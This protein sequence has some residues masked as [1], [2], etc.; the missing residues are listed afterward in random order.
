VVYA[1]DPT[2]PLLQPVA[3]SAEEIEVCHAVP[4]DLSSKMQR[5]SSLVDAAKGKATDSSKAVS[6]KVKANR[7][8]LCGHVALNR[9][10]ICI[11]S[12]HED[13]RF[14]DNADH[15]L[16]YRPQSLVSC[17]VLPPDE[18]EDMEVLGVIQVVSSKQLEERELDLLKRIAA[19]AARAMRNARSFSELEAREDMAKGLLSC[20]RSMTCELR[21]GSSGLG[22]LGQSSLPLTGLEHALKVL[23]TPNYRLFIR[24]IHGK[25]VLASGSAEV[26]SSIEISDIDDPLTPEVTIGVAAQVFSTG[27]SLN[28]DLTQEHEHY[29][30][31]TDLVPI[32][33]AKNLYATAIMAPDDAS[34]TRNRS[35]SKL[36]ANLEVLGVLQVLSRSNRQPFT[37]S[38]MELLDSIAMDFGVTMQSSMR[39]LALQQEQQTNSAVL[40]H[41]LNAMVALPAERILALAGQMACA[42][43][44]G[45][46]FLVFVCDDGWY[47]EGAALR[48]LTTEKG[49]LAI[50][51]TLHE[52]ET[53][54]QREEEKPPGAVR[55]ALKSK[56]ALQLSAGHE[57]VD[58]TT[59]MPK[60]LHANSLLCLP[61][62]TLEG[63]AFAAIVV[64]SP[65]CMF[66]DYEE[67]E[68]R[69]PEGVLGRGQLLNDIIGMV[70]NSIKDQQLSPFCTTIRGDKEAT[71]P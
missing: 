40:K 68:V 49:T 39:F 16:G 41:A 43:S 54:N 47:S 8:G 36:F 20:S 35:S 70:A 2:L 46:D 71:S 61:L 28:I 18:G 66:L 7:Y 6:G 45:V 67:G 11:Q 17:P 44:G 69:L 55:Q 27:E 53:D 5:R 32:P 30:L 31:Q 52:C 37:D 63:H 15:Y 26:G 42:T 64:Y 9:E 60:D 10:A 21:P 12:A 58:V 50:P 56:V 24:S 22:A 13:P 25:L 33:E 1:K 3:T 23:G 29:D 57:W 65:K 14:N 34:G 51:G 48:R 38:E 4:L 59:D 62:R 19:C